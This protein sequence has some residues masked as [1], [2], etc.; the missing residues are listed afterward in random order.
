[1]ATCSPGLSVIVASSGRPSLLDTLASFVPQLLPGDQVLVDVNDDSPWGHRARN[2]MM[3]KVP[4][5]YGMLFQDDDDA[6]LPGA[7]EVIRAAFHEQPDCIHMFRV[8][9]GHGRVEPEEFIWQDPVLREGN[10]STQCFL[11][12][13]V[14]CLMAEWGDRYAGDFDFIEA[15]VAMLGEPVWH[16]DL[17]AVLGGGK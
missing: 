16:K 2:R 7:L 3:L 13:Q 5:G 9:F 12:P 6:Y 14:E 15:A 1:M 8:G 10:V 4:P 11:V 17:I